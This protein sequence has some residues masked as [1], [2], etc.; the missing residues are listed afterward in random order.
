MPDV[1]RDRFSKSPPKIRR[2]SLLQLR[3]LHSFS[4]RVLLYVRLGGG[5]ISFWIC[6]FALS[7]KGRE[8]AVAEETYGH[9]FTATA[10]L[11]K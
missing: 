9:R 8:A 6:R 10:L 4:Y 7:L 3:W 11:R 5:D 1:S 2:V